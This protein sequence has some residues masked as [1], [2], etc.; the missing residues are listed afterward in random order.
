MQTSK[1][2][3]KNREFA[4]ITYLFLACFIGMMAYFTYFQV[5]VSED[6]INQS[7]NTRQDVLEEKVIRGSIYSA[8]D[9][10][11]AETIVKSDGS[12]LRNYPYD[13]LFFH[14]VG[15]SVQ[16]KTG[17]ESIA[18]FDL[19]RSHISYAD[20]VERQLSDEQLPG[21]NV[22][23]TLNY[24]LQKA[25]YDALSFYE[26]AVVVI[27][28][29]TGKIL[30][31]VS[32]PDYNPNYVLS[33]W[34]YLTAEDNDSTVLL[35]RATQGLYPPGS[36][37]KIFTTLE[38]IHENP[39][40]A[41]YSF[42]CNGKYNSGESVIHCYNNKSH[43]T[44]DLEESFAESCNSSFSAI[45]LGLDVQRFNDL[46]D[47]LLFNSELPTKF[48]YSK[49]RFSLSEDASDAEIMQRAI[50]QGETLVTP[51]H[52]ALIAS[53]IAND[54]VLMEPY[55]IDHTENYLGSVVKTYSPTE[56]G[57]LMSEEDA[58]ILQ[59]YMEATV[60]YGTATALSGQNYTAAGKTG[61]AEFSTETKDSHAWFVGYAHQD[62]ENDIA[63]AIIVEDSGSGSKYAVPIAKKIFDTY[64]EMLESDTVE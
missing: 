25:A 5:E 59:Q 17:I 57:R 14:V 34:D 46:C 42:S 41:E 28:P 32:K 50:G 20:K 35:N 53:A 16:G 51:F 4:V 19:L 31:M 36:T 52:M 47:D 64:Y 58:A 56:Y 10:V 60:E 43:G 39:D 63:V 29:S 38:Y 8:D 24:E 7:Q 37:F 21:D 13:N 18:N 45:G 11:L 22:Y 61:S 33:D 55:V 12:E 15:Y 54:G 9:M 26:G 30:A 1:T 6:F 44:V 40:F 49:S 3:H 27:E 2:S 23:T 62:G 48:A